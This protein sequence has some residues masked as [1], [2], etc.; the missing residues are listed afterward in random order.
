MALRGRGSPPGPWS[1]SHCSLTCA[2]SAIA[3]A[4]SAC[5]VR[6]SERIRSNPSRA[7]LTARIRSWLFLLAQ[8]LRYI[9]HRKLG[10]I[11]DIRDNEKPSPP[12]LYYDVK[13]A[14]KEEESVRLIKVC[15][16][17]VMDGISC[18]VRTVRLVD[19]DAVLVVLGQNVAT[20]LR[21]NGVPL[22]HVRLG[23][24]LLLF[25]GPTRHFL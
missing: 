7:I 3:A 13:T 5:P 11:Q 20:V 8:A 25:R 21:P 24:P 6:A 1:G 14:K 17:L 2:G 22:L 4:F 16:L 12:N 19:H 18:Y 15:L 10:L 23:F 9:I